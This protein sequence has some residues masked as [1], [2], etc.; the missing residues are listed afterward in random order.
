MHVAPVLSDDEQT[1]FLANSDGFLSMMK[2][3]EWF[4]NAD[5]RWW[6]IDG[7]TRFQLAQELSGCHVIVK[8]V[9]PRIP[10]LSACV[11]ATSLNEVDTQ[12]SILR[13]FTHSSIISRALGTSITRRRFS[14]K[15]RR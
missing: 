9:D 11:I 5:R 12:L 3:P 10:Y 6:I 8:I 1:A 2:T 13:S 7:A 14:R 4:K 15:S